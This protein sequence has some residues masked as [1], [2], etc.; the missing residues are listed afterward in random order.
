MKM[1]R[2]TKMLNKA[3]RLCATKKIFLNDQTAIYRLTKKKLRVDRKFN[4]QKKLTDKTVIRHFSMTL[5]F[6]P[7]FKKQNIKP[8]HVDKLHSVL[9]IHEFDDIL[10]KWQEIINENK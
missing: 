8:W 1:L 4:E 9:K 5:K 7:W 2:E 6:F 3:M 10:Q